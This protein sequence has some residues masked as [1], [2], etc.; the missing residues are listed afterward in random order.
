MYTP[1]REGRAAWPDEAFA[2]DVAEL[3]G[4]RAWIISLGALRADK[5]EP[6][7]D[8]RVAAKDRADLASLRRA[9]CSG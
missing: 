1:I 7:D 5:S 6:H 3:G 2:D 9:G 8:P 4:T